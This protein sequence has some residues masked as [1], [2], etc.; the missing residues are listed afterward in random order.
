MYNISINKSIPPDNITRDD[1]ILYIMNETNWY[2]KWH[3]HPYHAHCHWAVLAVAASVCAFFLYTYSAQA[4]VQPAPTQNPNRMPQDLKREYNEIEAL[5]QQ[6]DGLTRQAKA[7][8][9]T[10]A[11]CEMACPCGPWPC[12]NVDEATGLAHDQCITN[13]DVVVPQLQAM[14][15]QLKSLEADITQRSNALKQKLAALKPADLDPLPS[16]VAC[17]EDGKIGCTEDEARDYLEGNPDEDL[18][19]HITIYNDPCT[20]TKKKDCTSVSNMRPET[21]D[22]IT[23]LQKA[24]NCDL[25]ITGGTEG[26]HAVGTYSHTNGYKYDMSNDDAEHST[27][28]KYI[29]DNCTAKKNCKVDYRVNKNGTKDKRYTYNLGYETVEYVDEKSAA[30]G[31]HWDVSVLPAK[32]SAKSKTSTK[33]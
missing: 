26:A 13:C 1:N 27:V 29:T 21:L 2:H 25:K 10:G 6:Y 12:Q 24:C 20:A 28:N 19:T 7:I 16:A 14:A 9:D 8:Y 23:Q 30:G 15:G 33:K 32:T 11:A 17:G 22:Q 3:S 5:I 4:F 18:D 31:S